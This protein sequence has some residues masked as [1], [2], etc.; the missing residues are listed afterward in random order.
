MNRM[1]N[2]K[3]P[4][5]NHMAFLDMFFTEHLDGQMRSV[6]VYGSHTRMATLKHH[7]AILKIDLVDQL[8]W[9]MTKI[10]RQEMKL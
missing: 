10:K 4:L 5:S 1:T 8:K 2:I 3:R 9:D 6:D 7:Q